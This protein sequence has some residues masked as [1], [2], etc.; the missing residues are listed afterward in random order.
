MSLTDLTTAER[1][2]L[3]LTAIAVLVGLLTLWKAVSEYRRQGTI[4]RIEFFLEA[5]NRLKTNAQFQEISRL[6]ELD[7]PKLVEIPMQHKIEFVGFFEEI[8]LLVTSRVIRP[9]VA[10]YMFGY[11]ALKTW[12]SQNFWLLAERPGRPLDKEKEP[13]WFLFRTFVHS[14][15]PIRDELMAGRAHAR[16]H[17]L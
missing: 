13:Y 10:H 11:Y 15:A 16:R 7:D 2:D 4:K 5:R 12:E 1:F 3:G 6:L 17:V 9:E 8:A 14:M